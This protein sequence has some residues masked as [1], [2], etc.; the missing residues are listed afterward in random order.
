[1]STSRGGPDGVALATF[2]LADFF[3]LADFLPDG[4]LPD[5]FFALVGSPGYDEIK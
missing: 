4:F 5:F 2:D 3:L 1:M